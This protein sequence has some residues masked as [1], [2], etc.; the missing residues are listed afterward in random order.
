MSEIIMKNI[1][2]I[3]LRGLVSQI[4]DANKN[5]VKQFEFHLQEM[6]I[7][8]RHFAEMLRCFPEDSVLLG[9]E[10]NFSRRT[11]VLYVRSQGFDPV[12]PG[13]ELPM[14]KI[15]CKKYV[16]GDVVCHLE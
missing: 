3:D 1:D 13:E 5:R 12:L 16:N 6:Q 2:E 9:I 7:P 11:C 4:S 15:I 10:N 14:G 8:L